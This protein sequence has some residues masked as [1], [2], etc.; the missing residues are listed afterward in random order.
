MLSAL[1]LA[2]CATAP[3]QVTTIARQDLACP[4]ADLAKISSDRYAASGCGRGAVYVHLCDGRGCRWGRLRH[5]HETALAEQ[6]APSAAN[7]PREVVP[8]PPPEAR[9]VLPAPAPAVRQIL[10][11]P[12]SN[13]GD[14]GAQAPGQAAPDTATP[15]APAAA[16]APVPLSQG[17]VSAPYYAVVPDRPSVQRVAYAPPQPLVDDRP[18][19]PASGHQWVNGYWFWGTSGWVWLPGYWATPVVGYGYQPGYWYWSTNYWWYYPGGWCRPGSTTV[20]YQI[21]P[22]SQRTVHVR[23]FAARGVHRSRGPFASGSNG[24]H[25]IVHASRQGFRPRSSPLLSYPRSLGSSARASSTPGSSARAPSMRS[26]SIGRVVR[27]GP[28]ASR[29]SSFGSSRPYSGRGAPSRSSSGFWGGPRSSSGGAR[30]S[31]PGRAGGGSRA[32]SV[33]RAQRR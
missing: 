26:G 17:E 20:V 7:E 19:P 30:F 10:P 21:A 2:G 1:F 11:A 29:P 8:A 33:G 22:R 18:P 4:D 25:G 14:T 23:A 3:M 24:T 28:V 13:A 12:D 16:P 27:S 6:I 31:A 5:G 32:P 9:E 15:A